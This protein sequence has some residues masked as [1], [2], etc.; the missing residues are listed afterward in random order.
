MVKFSKFVAVFNLI[1]TFIVI[2]ALATLLFDN[3]T[4]AAFAVALLSLSV[5]I[6]AVVLTIPF[7]FILKAK[8]YQ[9]IKFYALTHL[10]LASSSIITL[11]I[12]LLLQ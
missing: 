10:G 1:F 4:N 12:S 2:S 6:I 7:I 11:I 3:N 5:A 8:G 9:D